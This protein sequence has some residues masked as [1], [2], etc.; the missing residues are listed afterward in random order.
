MFRRKSGKFG[1]AL[2]LVLGSATAQAG[3][4]QDVNLGG[5]LQGNHARV[6]RLDATFQEAFSFQASKSDPGAIGP[7]QIFDQQEVS[8]RFSRLSEQAAIVAL[9]GETSFAARLESA[10]VSDPAGGVT[11]RNFTATF[12][13][14]ALNSG[15]ATRVNPVGNPAISIVPEPTVLILLAA[16]I[17]ALIGRRRWRRR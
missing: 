16:G 4:V 10:N 3:F 1:I 14:V 9:L 6:G 13:A 2:A 7:D 15:T 11:T 8:D 12:D 17:P 5:A